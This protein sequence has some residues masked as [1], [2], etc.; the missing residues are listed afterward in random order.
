MIGS[1]VE[2]DWVESREYVAILQPKRGGLGF[3]Q[4]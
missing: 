4:V 3:D 1:A 2:E